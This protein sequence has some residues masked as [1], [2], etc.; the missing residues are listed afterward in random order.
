MRE[1]Y[2]RPLYGE[3]AQPGTPITLL[4]RMFDPWPMQLGSNQDSGSLINTPWTFVSLTPMDDPT[5]ESGSHFQAIGCSFRGDTLVVDTIAI[6]R[7][8]NF[9]SW[10]HSDRDVI[11]RWPPVKNHRLTESRLRIMVLAKA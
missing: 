1:K 10:F 5:Q 6:E 9:R 7:L 2:T 4:Q 8:P 11:K 3:C